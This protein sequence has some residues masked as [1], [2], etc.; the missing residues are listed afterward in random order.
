MEKV[1]PRVPRTDIS[2]LYLRQPAGRVAYFPFDIDRTFWEVLSPDHLKILR[3]TILWANNEAPTV[4]VDGPG[5]LDV[6]AWQNSSAITIHLVNLTNP[7][8][9]KGPYRDFFPV[10]PHTVKVRLPAGVHAGKARL[11]ASGKEVAIERSGN[12]LSVAVP[13]ILDHEVVAIDT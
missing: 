12:T 3:N 10:G 4:E 2:C 1:Y 5:L 9:M 13:S 8:A 11:L 6:T 7:M